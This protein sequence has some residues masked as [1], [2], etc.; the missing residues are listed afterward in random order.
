MASRGRLLGYRRRVI[1]VSHYSGDKPFVARYA[2]A[3]EAEFG[4]D[5]VF[6]DS[7]SIN[8][9]DDIV[10]GIDDALERCTHFVLF[11]TE[12]SLQREW[13][14]AEWH[15]AFVRKMATAT[16]LIPVR[17]DDCQPP[18]LLA[19][20]KGI[21][22]TDSGP[23]QATHELIAAIRGES[24]YLSQPE[25]SNITATVS[26]DERTL[27]VEIRVRAY[28]WHNPEITLMFDRAVSDVTQDINL[29][30][31][32]TVPGDGMH[33]FNAGGWE[34]RSHPAPAQRLA[35]FIELARPL[36]VGD[37][38]VLVADDPPARLVRVMKT[39]PEPQ[40]LLFDIL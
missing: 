28:I 5:R 38:V 24:T 39:R 16:T 30:S 33:R 22:A 40:E 4:R 8:P 37:P 11:M 2:D 21:D 23:E 34:S 18:P 20:L 14:Q 6:Y 10:G 35:V 17:L 36:T 26:Q 15:A 27:R 3:L 9:G 19:S 32:I 7:W 12:A 13:V 29:A 31:R 1:F 25:P